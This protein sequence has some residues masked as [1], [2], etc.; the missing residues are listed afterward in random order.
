MRVTDADARSLVLIHQATLT[1]RHTHPAEQDWI[2]SAG[3][4]A[5]VL[6]GSAS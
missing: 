3:I 6:T 4:E 1:T 2:R 5:V